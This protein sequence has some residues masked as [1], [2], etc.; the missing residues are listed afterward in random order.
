MTPFGVKLRQS[1]D[2]MAVL[3]GGRLV[4]ID[5]GISAV[6]GGKLGWVEIEGGKM[7]PHEVERP[8]AQKGSG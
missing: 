2:R 8:K 1:V 3:Y 5:T 7:V 6:F 4:R